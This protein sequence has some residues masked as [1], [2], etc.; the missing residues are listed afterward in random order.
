VRQNMDNAATY[1]FRRTLRGVGALLLILFVLPSV[2]AEPEKAIPEGA[3][4]PELVFLR[5]AKVPT[6]DNGLLTYLRRR[7]EA[8]AD[9]SNLDRLIV[10]LSDDNFRVRERAV[11]KLVRIGQPALPALRRARTAADKELARRAAECVTRILAEDI[12]EVP[13]MVVNRLLRRQPAGMVEGLLHFLPFTNDEAI[14]ADIYFGLDHLAG[15]GG[16]IHRALVKVLDDPMPARRAVAACIVGRVGDVP[17]R[18]QVRRLLEDPIPGVRL[19]AAQGLLAAGDKAGVPTLIALLE[20]PPVLLGWQAEELL[21]WAAGETAPDAMLGQATPAARRLCQEAWQAWWRKHGPE[22]DLRQQA[23]ERSRPGLFL[24]KDAERRATDMEI[25]GGARLTL[26]GCDC[27]PRWRLANLPWF[28]DVAL[29]PGDRVWFEE[30]GDKRLVVRDLQGKTLRELKGDPNWEHLF[31]SRP[32]PNGNALVVTATGRPRWTVTVRELTDK[33][34]ADIRAEFMLAQPMALYEPWLRLPDGR[35]FSVGA[36]IN[37]REGGTVERL[38][39]LLPYEEKFGPFTVDQ[40]LPSFHLVTVNR[41]GVTEW[42]WSGHVV[43]ELKRRPQWPALTAIR[44]RN[45]NTLVQGKAFPAFT[46][47]DRQGHPIWEL[48]I[49]PLDARVQQCLPLL[50]VGFTQRPTPGSLDIPAV[51]LRQ[52]HHKEAFVRRY[53]AERLGAL[54]VEPDM[55]IPALAKALDDDREV[56]EVVFSSLAR[57]GPKCIPMVEKALK[58]PR[59]HVRAQAANRLGSEAL[60]RHAA[61]SIPRLIEALTDTD[62]DVRLSAIFSLFSFNQVADQVVP[63]LIELLK[64]ADEKVAGYAARAVGHWG[65]KAAGAVPHLIEALHDKRQDVAWGAAC[66]LERI[67]PEAASAVHALLEAAKRGEPSVRCQAIRAMGAIGPAAAPAAPF[68]TASLFQN[69][70]AG[71]RGPIAYALGALGPGMAKTTMPLLVKGLQTEEFGRDKAAMAAG[72]AL[73]GADAALAAQPLIEALKDETPEVA[74]AAARALGHIGPAAKDAVPALMELLPWPSEGVK[75][76]AAADR[77]KLRTAAVWALG[78]LGPCAKPALPALERL[79]GE[80]LWHDDDQRVCTTPHRRPANIAPKLKFQ[81]EVREALR[82][83]REQ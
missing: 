75:F 33:G 46:E 57:F 8:Q 29:L 31:L 81:D 64:D 51:R 28:R 50:Q 22:L 70:Y 27:R 38:D 58:H 34:Q 54:A 36:A 53:A 43:W 45:G 3:P 18:A 20:R 60:S 74:P 30:R 7:A 26:Y 25:V 76:A 68:L 35:F 49:K 47:V 69:E 71:C 6:D 23:P 42:D 37:P 32:L 73:L 15:A 83:I 19:R 56:T 40:I 48:P 16:K 1:S 39:F 10:S 66:S 67:G 52:L 62:Q 12:E 5:H 2:G 4:G 78:R 41:E 59:P 21:R 61:G 82:R 13:R 14:E 55:V 72:L 80:R 63:A 77:A 9:L 11:E 24:V 79:I 44:L 17:Q 65:K